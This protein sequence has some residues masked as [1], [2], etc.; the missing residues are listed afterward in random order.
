MNSWPDSIKIN[1]AAIEDANTYL[2][3]LNRYYIK[4]YNKANTQKDE[5]VNNLQKSF[6]S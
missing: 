5:L 4:R 3:Q 2:D 1:D 6:K